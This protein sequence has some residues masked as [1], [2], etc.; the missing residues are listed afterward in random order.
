[1]VATFVDFPSLTTTTVLEY[2]EHRTNIANGIGAKVQV[3]DFHSWEWV[4]S[5][6]K[7]L[8]FSYIFLTQGL[9][10]VLYVF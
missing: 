1:M 10:T 2:V 3:V 5:H 9:T 7:K 4:L 8:Q 6:E